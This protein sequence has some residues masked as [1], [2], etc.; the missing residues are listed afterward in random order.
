VIR[1]LGIDAVE[2][3][4]IRRLVGRGAGGPR[5][6]RF[7]DRCFTKGEQ[8]FCDARQD[9]P[10]HYAARFAAKEAAM[11]AL[12]APVGLRFTELEV[13]RGGGPPRLRL[14]GG[15]A[16]AAR[17]LRVARAHLTLTHDGGLALAA[18]VLEG[19]R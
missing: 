1:G 6:R 11:K 8:A 9:P 4:R 18:V 19:G 5:A 12:G 10:T 17:R 7:R 15:A 2:V 3:A 13:E 16:R 14:H